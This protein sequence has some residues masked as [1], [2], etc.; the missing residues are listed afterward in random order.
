MTRKP[1]L[2]PSRPMARWGDGGPW[3]VYL[4]PH[5]PFVAD[6]RDE[7]PPT[8]ADRYVA[9]AT[10]HPPTIRVVVKD[11]ETGATAQ[12]GRGD[13]IVLTIPTTAPDATGTRLLRDARTIIGIARRQTGGPAMGSGLQPSQVVAAMVALW[14]PEPAPD[15]TPPTQPAVGKELLLSEHD[16]GRTIRRIGGRLPGPGKPWERLL[17]DARIA[18]RQD[19]V[20]LAS[21]HPAPSVPDD[22]GDGRI[23]EPPPLVAG[24]ADP[25]A[26]ESRRPTI[27]RRR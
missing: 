20:R 26:S 2:P 21:S 18:R 24:H 27:A 13:G 5:S 7:Q 23:D 12:Q 8:L 9:T 17:R 19:S 11:R 4:G 14:N 3:S 6:P 15:G 22:G 10:G 16:E 1:K 25:P